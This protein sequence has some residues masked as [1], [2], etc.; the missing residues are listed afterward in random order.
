[1][2]N[3]LAHFLSFPFTQF[4]VPPLLGMVM[5]LKKLLKKNEC[6]YII[7]LSI[8]SVPNYQVARGQQNILKRKDLILHIGH[9]T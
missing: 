3:S 8:E 9:G 2:A 5:T 4:F 1:M 6:S 7:H